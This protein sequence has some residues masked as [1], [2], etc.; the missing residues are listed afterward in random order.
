[1]FNGQ[2]LYILKMLGSR[3]LKKFESSESCLTAACKASSMYES[4]LTHFNPNP[5]TKT[6][7]TSKKIPYISGNGTFLL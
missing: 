3:N 6:K 2:P 7:S 4:C 1:M 5:K